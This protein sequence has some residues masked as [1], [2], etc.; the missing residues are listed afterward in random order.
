MQT[1]AESSDTVS[2]DAFLYQQRSSEEVVN[3]I[4]ETILF[5]GAKILQNHY[6]Q[7]QINPY[8]AKTICQELIMNS[9]WAKLPLGPPLDEIDSDDDLELPKIDQW[10]N[11]ALVVE[12]PTNVQLRTCVLKS[13]QKDS[14]PKK[15]SKI[16]INLNSN[17]DNSNN[18]NN[19]INVFSNA[20]SNSLSSLNNQENV[21]N[22]KNNNFN[23]KFRNGF[24]KPNGLNSKI[25][26]TN[27]LNANAKSKLSQVSSVSKK[28]MKSANATKS[29]KFNPT[30]TKPAKPAGESVLIQKIFEETKKNTNKNITIDSDF[31]II[32]VA[33]NKILASSLIVPKV[34]TKKSP[35][36]DSVVKKPLNK[37]KGISTYSKVRSSLGVSKKT[38]KKRTLPKLIEAD[39]PIFDDET[40]QGDI[41]DVFECAPGVTLKDGSFVKS[42]SK[43]LK[44]NEFTRAQYNDYITQIQ[45]STDDF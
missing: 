5:N 10:A 21:E 20:S 44:P 18:S 19:E 15:N 42:K 12:L 30:K 37:G 45:N 43:P 6:L 8:S 31:N 7:T 24:K 13:S 17:S 25:S 27:K 33:E 4:I 28:A 40:T 32:E 14:R 1:I 22:E 2:L 36:I 9:T 41:T 26:T 38:T 29:S 23:S 35:K 11:G 39:S 16:N 3:D 34:A